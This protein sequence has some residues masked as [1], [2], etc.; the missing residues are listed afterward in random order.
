M[1]G[2]PH[3]KRS[4]AL[5]LYRIKEWLDKSFP[6]LVFSK[7]VRIPHSVISLFTNSPNER[8]QTPARK[9][10]YFRPDLIHT[11]L[12]TIVNTYRK[13]EQGKADE[14]GGQPF[15]ALDLVVH[16]PGGAI[17]EVAMLRGGHER[18][19]GSWTKLPAR[20][21]GCVGIIPR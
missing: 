20:N 10:S 6:P 21:K 14:A 1:I 17:P 3:K 16:R 11:S 15:H 4:E 13:S 12:N 19:S 7:L 18:I 8:T 9:P 2:S 5:L